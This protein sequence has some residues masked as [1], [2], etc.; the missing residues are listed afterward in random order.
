M[1]TME[2]FGIEAI[3]ETKPEIFSQESI[4]D[5]I[6]QGVMDQ[7]TANDLIIGNE[8]LTPGRIDSNDIVAIKRNMVLK[9]AEAKKHQKVERLTQTIA[10]A[11]KLFDEVAKDVF[12]DVESSVAL[13]IKGDNIPEDVKRAFLESTGLEFM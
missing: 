9:I 6:G 7:G 8:G 12:D 4:Y 10:E 13:F 1:N 3:A 11:K 2:I 5:F